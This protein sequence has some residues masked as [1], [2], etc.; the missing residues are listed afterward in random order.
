MS[1]L[2]TYILVTLTMVFFRAENINIALAYLGSMFNLESAQWLHHI[3]QPVI[4]DFGRQLSIDISPMLKILPVIAIA[5][6]W[7][8]L[9]PNLQQIMNDKNALT[10]IRQQ[11][12][13]LRWKPSFLWAMITALALTA[14]IMSLDKTGEFVYFQF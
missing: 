5:H 7:I 1:V 12:T 13:A 4:S 8:W 3:Q 11:P 10:H 6:I 14:S 9:L 2:M